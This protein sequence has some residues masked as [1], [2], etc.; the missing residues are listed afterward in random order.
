VISDQ[1]SVISHQETSGE[2]RENFAIKL[3]SKFSVAELVEALL[4]S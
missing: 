4:T 2:K 3:T 1:S